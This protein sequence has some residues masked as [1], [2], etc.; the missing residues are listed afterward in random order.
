MYK[1]PGYIFSCIYLAAEMVCG[2]RLNCGAGTEMGIIRIVTK[3]PLLRG[4]K[5]LKM[6]QLINL[7][8]FHIV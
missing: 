6:V 4:S 7:F 8:I 2:K 1:I 5:R 3:M